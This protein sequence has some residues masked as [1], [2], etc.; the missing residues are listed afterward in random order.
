MR[1]PHSYRCGL[2][3]SV[4]SS[5]F[6]IVSVDLQ[7]PLLREARQQAVIAYVSKVRYRYQVVNVSDLNAGLPFYRVP[8]GWYRVCM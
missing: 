5:I 2:V 7:Q 8:A 6:Q 3:V 4:S 1:Q